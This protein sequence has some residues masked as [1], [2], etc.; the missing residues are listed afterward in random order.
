MALAA[1]AIGAEDFVRIFVGLLIIGLLFWLASLPGAIARKRDN[2]SATAI[3]VLAWGG[4]FLTGGLLWLVALVWALAVPAAEARVHCPRCAELI[5]AAAKV[6]KHCGA[7]IRE[8]EQPPV[9]VAI[10]HDRTPVKPADALDNE[11]GEDDVTPAA[12]RTLWRVR[13]I[14]DDGKRQIARV[15][16]ETEQDARQKASKVLVEIYSVDRI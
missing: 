11:F 6:C 10:G 2:P 9:E 15:E 3:A 16:A 14:S 5:L 8:D 1:S 7:R 4:M 13:G 12:A